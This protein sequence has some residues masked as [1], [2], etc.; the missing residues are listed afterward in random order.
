M[1]PKRLPNSKLKGVGAYEAPLVSSLTDSR[2]I[3]DSPGILGMQSEL[4][5]P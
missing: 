4:V 3:I 5:S 2:H 1:L